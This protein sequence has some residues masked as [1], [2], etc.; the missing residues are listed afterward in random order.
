MGYCWSKVEDTLLP[1]TTISHGHPGAGLK[2]K[3]LPN[4][5]FSAELITKRTLLAVISMLYDPTGNF[6]SIL[7]MSLK[8]LYSQVCIA[9]PG[10]KQKRL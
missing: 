10:K 7:K 2:G 4:N 1:E 5:P 6:Y 3:L 9:L 8:A